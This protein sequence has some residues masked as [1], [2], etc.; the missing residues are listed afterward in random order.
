[1]PRGY[2]SINR[3]EA[4]DQICLISIKRNLKSSVLWSDY[5]ATPLQ[6]NY[7]SADDWLELSG[8]KFKGYKLY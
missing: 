7:C 6:C 2:K 5:Q 8:S 3:I 4:V 1:M